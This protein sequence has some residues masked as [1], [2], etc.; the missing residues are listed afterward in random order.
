LPSDQILSSNESEGGPSIGWDQ[1]P[2][3]EKR[4]SR[5]MHMLYP[6]I[7]VVF[8]WRGR[9]R[10]DPEPGGIGVPLPGKSWRRS[11]IRLAYSE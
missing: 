5:R 4:G 11:R 7:P 10:E 3:G 9:V 1:L 8:T 2:D 6:T